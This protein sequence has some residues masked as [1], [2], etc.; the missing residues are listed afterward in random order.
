MKMRK[1]LLSLSAALVAAIAIFGVNFKVQAAPKTMPD[2]TVFDAEYYAA[3][4]PDVVA[5]CEITVLQP[6]LEVKLNTTSIHF[7]EL[8]DTYQLTATVL[9]ED[10]SDKSVKW[11]SSDENVCTISETGLVTTIG[12]GTATVTVTSVDGGKTATCEVTISIPVKS[13]VL[14]MATLQM[15]VGESQELKA[16]VSPDNATDKTLEW[17]S[18]DDAIATVDENGIVTT[19]KAGK[20]TITAK[21]V[22]NPDVVA[23]C[24]V[25]VIQPVSEVKLDVASIYFDEL[26]KTHQLTATVLPEDASEK[27]VTWVSSDDAVCTVSET[28]LVTAVGVGNA[29]IIV[30]TVDG[31]KTAKCNVSVY[32]PVKSITLNMDTLEMQVGDSRQLE[33]T[34]LPDNA[35]DKSIEWTSSDKAV[36]TVD[37]NGVV[38]A[39]KEGSAYIMVKSVS[40]PDVTAICEVT[41]TIED[42]IITMT[43]GDMQQVRAI[44]DIAGRKVEALHQGLNIVLMNDGT[45]RKVYMK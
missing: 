16:I 43:T 41:V 44:Y 2:G 27:A 38:T 28:G 12:V 19:K 30:I 18:S 10:A 20:A 8:G 32:I 6:V 45:I 13:I 1:A 3:S 23:T 33:A 26:G 29:T 17:T 11:I 15:K 21:S 35:T 40:N 22:S 39:I 4:N 36:A 7:E 42:G 37:A 5:S 9:P 25:T 34:I 31:G 14:N 24:E